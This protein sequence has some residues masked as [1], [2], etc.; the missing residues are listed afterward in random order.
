VSWPEFKL[1]Y[2]T[3]DFFASSLSIAFVALLETLISA[4]IADSMTKTSFNQRK[5]VFGLSLANI[6]TGRAPSCFTPFHIS[7]L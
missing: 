6:V 4:K 7:H 1:S 2:I 3:I 5:E